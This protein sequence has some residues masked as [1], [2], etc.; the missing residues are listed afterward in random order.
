MTTYT[1]D[2][3]LPTQQG[4][5]MQIAMQIVTRYKRRPS[6][7]ELMRDFGMSRATAFRWASAAKWC[8]P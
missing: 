4:R 6:Y 1:A 7:K 2:A 5:Y 8:M 3:P